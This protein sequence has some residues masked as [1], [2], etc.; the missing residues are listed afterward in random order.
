MSNMTT[1]QKVYFITAW[2]IVGGIT[3]AFITEAVAFGA[4]LKYAPLFATSQAFDIIY[5][6]IT[7][8]F[9]LFYLSG[10]FTNSL[11]LFIMAWVVAGLCLLS[12]ILMMSANMH[13]ALSTGTF[14]LHVCFGAFCTLLLL[15]CSGK[16]Q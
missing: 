7:A 15:R 13:P 14:F 10:W 6:G 3:I 1:M 2:C 4:F 9:C 16:F 12:M 11:V 5:Q 8:V